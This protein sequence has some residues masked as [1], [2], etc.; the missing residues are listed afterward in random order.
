MVFYEQQ[1]ER[2]MRAFLPIIGQ[3]LRVIEAHCME[4]KRRYKMYMVQHKITASGAVAASSR[5]GLGPLLDV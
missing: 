2:R 5:A 1:R 3:W 4:D